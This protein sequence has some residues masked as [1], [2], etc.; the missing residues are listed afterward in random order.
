MVLKDFIKGLIWYYTIHIQDLQTDAPHQS[1]RHRRTLASS[2]EFSFRLYQE[3]TTTIA[4]Y[5]KLFYGFNIQSTDTIEGLLSSI[6]HGVQPPS[7][8]LNSSN[9]LIS[10]IA[11][12]IAI[13][14]IKPTWATLLMPPSVSPGDI[15]RRIFRCVLSFSSDGY[16]FIIFLFGN[17]TFRISST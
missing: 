3:E 10:G 17:E 6:I 1:R 16:C 2:H 15:C 11:S 12:K 7:L 13:D 5:Y 9:L 4:I 14:Q 8:E